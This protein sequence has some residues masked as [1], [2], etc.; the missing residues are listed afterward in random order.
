MLK[1]SVNK[2]KETKSNI[3]KEANTVQ[4]KAS[5]SI[6]NLK[7]NEKKIY[8]LSKS[9]TELVLNV[10]THGLVAFA[11]ANL[12]FATNNLFLVATCGIVLVKSIHHGIK[13]TKEILNKKVKKK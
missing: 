1:E 5:T 13:S 8:E 6:K 3:V 9:R 7:V 11:V 10:A 4:Q 12:A 2:V